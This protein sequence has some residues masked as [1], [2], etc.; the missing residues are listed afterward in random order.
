[1]FYKYLT[2]N[3]AH[4]TGHRPATQ[5]NSTQFLCTYNFVICTQPDQKCL[6]TKLTNNPSKKEK[7][8]RLVFKQLVTGSIHPASPFWC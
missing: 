4:K 3:S 5:L 7:Q 1:M 2:N 8:D 6:V